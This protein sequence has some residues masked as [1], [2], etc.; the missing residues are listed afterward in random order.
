MADAAVNSIAVFGGSGA[1]GRHVIRKALEQGLRVRALVRPGSPQPDS[2]AVE[3]VVG[4]LLEFEDVLK[5]L[6]ESNAVCCVFGA[7]PPYTDVFC[8]AATRIIIDAMRKAGVE[9]LVCQTGAMIGD[10][11]TNRTLPFRLMASAFN[12]RAPEVAQD[13]VEQERLVRESS[14]K[15]TIVKPPRLTEEQP[16][17]DH[18]R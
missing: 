11:R 12:S 3:A 15:W 4:A 14:L 5:T 8:A 1:T 10:Y 18:L 2:S 7:R 16:L 13:R 9:R 17:A 6:S